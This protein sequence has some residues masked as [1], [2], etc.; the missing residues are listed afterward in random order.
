VEI[1]TSDGLGRLSL[2]SVAVLVIL[3]MVF[4]LV[5]APGIAL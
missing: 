2:A 1:A 3:I 5:L 4:K